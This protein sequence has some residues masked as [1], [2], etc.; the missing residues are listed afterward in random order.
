[1]KDCG[2]D[3]IPYYYLWQAKKSLEGTK[4]TIEM[5][6]D[7]DNYMLEAQRDMLEL[8]VE[9]FRFESLKFTVFAVLTIFIISSIMTYLMLKGYINV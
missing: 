7:P 3:M 5:M 2:I 1:M 4:K 6:N 9:H 8:E